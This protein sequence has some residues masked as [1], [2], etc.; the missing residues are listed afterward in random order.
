M[1]DQSSRIEKLPVNA[2]HTLYNRDSLISIQSSA[3]DTPLFSA[4]LATST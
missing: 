4:F 3:E 2:L 1:P